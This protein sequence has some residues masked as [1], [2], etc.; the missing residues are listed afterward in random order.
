MT[1][2]L[3]GTLRAIVRD[4]LS[5]MRPPELAQVTQL[6]PSSSD[7]TANHQIDVKLRRSGVELKRVP[8]SVSRLGL[9]ILPQVDDL[10][11]VAFLGGDLN[12]P[13]VLGCLYDDQAHPPKAD[14]HEVVYT[15]P[16]PGDSGVRRLYVELSSGAKLTL[17]D[18]TVKVELGDTSLI[19]NRDGDVSL[20]S[21]GKI[22]LSAQGDITLDAQGDIKLSAQ[23]DLKL[24]G[25]SATLEG[26]SSTTVKG[27]SIAVNGMTQFSPS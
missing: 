8:M 24:T 10:V 21:K 6:Y 14:E 12:A 23:G 7:D 3:L 11:V 2:N 20:K 16:D 15:P 27:P 9:S 18:D 17:D 19:V 25:M 13:V 1:T 5:R 22:E 26:Q 4:E